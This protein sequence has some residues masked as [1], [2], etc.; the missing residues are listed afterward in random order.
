MEEENVQLRSKFI[1]A[2]KRQ[3]ILLEEGLAPFSQVL[4]LSVPEAD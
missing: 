1:L 4:G 2:Y 3:A